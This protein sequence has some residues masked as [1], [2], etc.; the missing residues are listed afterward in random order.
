MALAVLRVIPVLTDLVAM[1]AGV[2]HK[3]VL[4]EVLVLM[5]VL[6]ALVV[7]EVGK[8]HM[9]ALADLEDL[10][11]MAV[12]EVPVVLE[13]KKAGVVLTE[14][15]ALM[16]DLVDLAVLMVVPVAPVRYAEP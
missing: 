8:A 13:A 14:A 9:E 7:R 12:P 2:V 10:L 1:E 11:L 4:Q 15:L 3:E 5:A 6:A 16:V